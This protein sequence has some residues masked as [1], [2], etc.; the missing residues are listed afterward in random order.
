MGKPDNHRKAGDSLRENGATRKIKIGQL[1]S[2]NSTCQRGG[3]CSER[4]EDFSDPDYGFVRHVRLQAVLEDGIRRFSFSYVNEGHP[5]YS[6]FL[7]CAHETIRAQRLD[8]FRY[9]CDGALTSGLEFVRRRHLRG[10]E[11]D[12]NEEEEFVRVDRS[13]NPKNRQFNQEIWAYKKHPNISLRIKYTDN[14]K[15][16]TTKLKVTI[17]FVAKTPLDMQGKEVSFSE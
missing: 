16:N 15:Q 1:R 12:N 13:R 10:D 3:T 2:E 5:F 6:P 11:K 14:R 4:I 9:F 17:G 8:Q 7:R